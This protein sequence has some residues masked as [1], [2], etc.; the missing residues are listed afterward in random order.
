MFTGPE[1]KNTK[2]FDFSEDECSKKFIKITVFH[3]VFK[4]K[5][6]SPH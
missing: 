4:K 5:D 2:N 1:I 3:K 6:I